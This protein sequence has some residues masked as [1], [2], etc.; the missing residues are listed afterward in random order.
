M[1]TL[2]QHDPADAAFAA[3]F[4]SPRQTHEYGAQA[5][6]NKPGVPKQIYW[7]YGAHKV[8]D[9]GTQMWTNRHELGQDYIV[10]KLATRC[11]IVSPGLGTNIGPT[12]TLQQGTMAIYDVVTDKFYI[13]LVPGDAG[14]GWRN[15]F[16]CYDPAAD[17][18]PSIHRPQQ[19]C[20]E[21]MTWVQAG[22]YIYGITSPYS[23]PYPNAENRVGFR[24]HI[25]NQTFEYF[26]LTGNFATYQ[27]SAGSGAGGQEAVP[28]LHDSTRNTLVGWSHNAVDRGNLYELNLASFGSHGGTGTYADPFIWP[29]SKIAL[30]GT[31]PSNVSYKY[32]AFWHMPTW[33]VYIFLPQANQPMWVIKR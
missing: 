31:P 4:S 12:V 6:R 29:Q 14:G 5:V 11:N 9:F 24:F 3:P 8:Y 28:Y 13:T 33:G 25:D 7:F 18:V 27:Q 26:I 2:A 22:R 15:F 17:T 20:R 1:R 21:S 32:N 10:Q 23:V 16:F 19:P 30:N